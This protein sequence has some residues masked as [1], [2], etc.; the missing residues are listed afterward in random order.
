M[1]NADKIARAIIRDKRTFEK[2]KK[3]ITWRIGDVVLDEQINLR[4]T[5]R[6]IIIEEIPNAFDMW[7]AMS[8]EEE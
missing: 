7:L 5:I 3:S 2:L 1:D 4:D 6:A 8:G